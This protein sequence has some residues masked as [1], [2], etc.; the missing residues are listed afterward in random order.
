MF[1]S[2][3]FSA[4]GLEA[5]GSPLHA[6]FVRYFGLG[7]TV[8]CLH[9]DGIHPSAVAMPRIRVSYSLNAQLMWLKQEAAELCQVRCCC[10]SCISS[11]SSDCTGWSSNASSELWLLHGLLCVCRSLLLTEL[12]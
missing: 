12:L 4:P 2:L 5:F 3:C 11:S 8:M 1:L 10:C 7:R 9:Q 6:S